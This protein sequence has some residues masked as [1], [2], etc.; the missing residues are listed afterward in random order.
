M[1]TI[2]RWNENWSGSYL[3]TN[4]RYITQDGSTPPTVVSELL[5]DPIPLTIQSVNE[6]IGSYQL[7]SQSLTLDVLNAVGLAYRLCSDGTPVLQISNEFISVGNLYASRVDVDRNVTRGTLLVSFM[8][9]NG[10]IS[11]VVQARFKRVLL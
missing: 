3:M 11:G 6:S 5:T 8:D 2:Q 4:V 1:G 10:T 7:T 9:Y